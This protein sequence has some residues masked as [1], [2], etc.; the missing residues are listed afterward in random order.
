MARGLRGGGLRR[1]PPPPWPRMSYDEAM[2]R[3]GADRP[4]TRFGLEIA[5]VGDAAARQRVQGLRER[6]RR[7]RRRA[8]DQRGRARDVRARSSTGSPRSCSAT[9]PR[10]S[11]RSR[12]RTT[13][14]GARQPREVLHAPSRSPAVNAELE[15]ADGDLLLFVADQPPRRAGRA[16]RAAAGAGRALRPGP[17]GPPR[18]RC[19]SSTSRCSSATEAARWTA[20]HHPFTAPDAATF[21][22]PGA[23]RSRAY[24]LVARRLRDRRRLDPHPHARGAAAG[25][26]GARHGA[27]RR[28]R[29]A[30]ASC[31][32]RCATARRRTAASRWAST[33]S[34]RSLAGRE[35]IRDVI[36]FPKTASGADPLTGAPAPVDDAA[37]A[38]AGAVALARRTAAPSGSSIRRGDAD[39]W[40]VDQVS[41]PVLIA[42]PP[43]SPSRAHGSR[44]CARRRDRGESAPPVATAPGQA[45][46]ERSIDKAN[47][48]VAASKASADAAEQAAADAS[49]D[50]VWRNARARAPASA[51]ATAV[52]GQAR[53]RPRQPKPALPALDDGRPLRSDP[54]GP[55]RRQGRRRALLRRRMAPTTTRRCARSA[56]RTAGTAGDRRTRSRSRTSATTPR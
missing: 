20:I 9:A 49:S 52:Q 48:A 43:S 13:A 35:S 5:D 21:D 6:A 28:R 4:D 32:T 1:S 36:A 3:F 54:A 55:R 44:C 29:R 46:L 30:S 15:A 8:R 47:G 24:D 53:R 39:T 10:P 42:L 27:R 2:L 45:G 7:R 31:S 12:R 50:D 17:R 11:R 22:D 23:L 40:N 16:R 33:A 18:H 25:L 41:R 56:R 38:R 37:A 14:A 34:S 19:G 26:R 51:T